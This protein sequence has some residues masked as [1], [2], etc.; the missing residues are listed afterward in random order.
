MISEKDKIISIS[1]PKI[2]Y[3]K[4][5]LLR[6]NRNQTGLFLAEGERT[7]REA[8]EHKWNPKYLIYSNE[9]NQTINFN[10][11]IF[12][13]KKNN[14]LVLN[15]TTKIIGKISKKIILKLCWVSL[16]KKYLIKSI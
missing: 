12:E 9:K 16:N 10:D 14:G 6:K 5:L 1:N 11:L 4:S 2:K 3:I 7:C 13:C 8:I 15:V